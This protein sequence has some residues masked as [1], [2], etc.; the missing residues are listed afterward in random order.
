MNRL[1]LV[2]QVYSVIN[3]PLR[4]HAMRG[5]PSVCGAVVIAVDIITNDE[6][7]VLSE[8]MQ[9]SLLGNQVLAPRKAGDL[10]HT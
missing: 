1:W 9:M 4:Y 3:T 7:L 2:E 10:S 5:T 8:R 6:T